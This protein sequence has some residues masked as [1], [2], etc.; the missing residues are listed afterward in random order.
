MNGPDAENAVSIINLFILIGFAILR[1][2]GQKQPCGSEGCGW[3]LV[4]LNINIW[5]LLVCFRTRQ[6]GLVG[7]PIWGRGCSPVSICRPLQSLEYCSSINSIKGQPFSLCPSFVNDSSFLFFVVFHNLGLAAKQA[8]FFPWYSNS[9]FWSRGLTL[10]GLW[11]H[12]MGEVE[13]FAPLTKLISEGGDPLKSHFAVSPRCSECC[14][15]PGA[16]SWEVW[17]TQGLWGPFR[18]SRVA[19]ID[20]CHENS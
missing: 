8:D 9:C 2:S 20:G 14:E 10:P 17:L 3:G 4:C 6:A 13:R 11:Y 19:G 5:K 1:S 15:R 12:R 18:S 7:H 16:S